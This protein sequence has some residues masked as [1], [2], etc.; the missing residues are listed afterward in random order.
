[1]LN[2][3]RPSAPLM[4][5]VMVGTQT[6]CSE[7]ARFLVT[8]GAGFGGLHLVDPSRAEASEAPIFVAE[9]M[10]ALSE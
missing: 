9:Q 1:M 5:F 3:P 8:G 10:P 7:L 6:E 4:Q 2:S